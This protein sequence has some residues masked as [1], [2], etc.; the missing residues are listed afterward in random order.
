[1]N[2]APTSSTAKKVVP[3]GLGQ[4]VVHALPVRNPC[5][6]FAADRATPNDLASFQGFD[7]WK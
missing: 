1:M 6:Q 3:M 7:G 4:A 5:G 2:T